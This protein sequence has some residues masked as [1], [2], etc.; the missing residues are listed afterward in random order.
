MTSFLPALRFRALTRVYDPVV[1]ATTRESTFKRRLLDQAALQPGHRVLDLGCGTG[2]LAL[3]AK[4]RSPDI[5][6]VGLDADPDVL[7]RASAKADDAAATVSFDLGLSTQLPYEE[8]S[9]D[10]VLSSLFFHHLT[11]QDKRR[12]LA[13]VKRVLRASGELHIADWGQPQDPAMR[14]AALSIRV[15]DGRERTSQNLDG[16]LPTLI[17]ESGLAD[18]RERDRFRTVFG[19]MELF[20]ARRPA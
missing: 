20:S 6:L 18:V 17:E 7:S 3:L 15:L 19:T 8:A 4:Q 2:T 14:A 9:F 13:E 1:R 5:D 11:P 10:R 16:R 12:T